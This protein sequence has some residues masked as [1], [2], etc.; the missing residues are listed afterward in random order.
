MFECGSN[1][2]LFGFYLF[3]LFFISL[4]FLPSFGL[5]EHVLLHYFNLSTMILT[6]FLLQFL[7]FSLEMTEFYFTQSIQDKYCILPPQSEQRNLTTIKV[8]F[9]SCAV[10]SYILHIHTLKVTQYNLIIFTF[11]HSSILKKPRRE[12]YFIIF[13]NSFTSSITLF[14]FLMFQ[15]SLCQL[16]F[17]LKASF[18]HYF[19]AGLWAMVPFGEQTINWVFEYLKGKKNPLD[20]KYFKKSLKNIFGSQF[21]LT[22]LF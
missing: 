13:I 22:S 21:L 4:P 7:V 19:R 5:F 20:D 17:V 11:N 16:P 2:L 15:V 3:P 1:V 8:P 18:S 12:K 9:K 14:K 6:I 10:F